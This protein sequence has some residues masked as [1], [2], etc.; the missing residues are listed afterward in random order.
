MKFKVALFSILS[1]V[2]LF[3]CSSSTDPVGVIDPAPTCPTGSAGYIGCWDT[4]GCQAIA[5]NIPDVP[6][7]WVVDRIYLTANEYRYYR[8]AY[9]DASCNGPLAFAALGEIHKFTVT[10]P[11]LGASGLMEYQLQ[12]DSNT[13]NSTQPSYTVFAAATNNALCLSNNWDVNNEGFSFHFVDGT[14][15]DLSNCLDAAP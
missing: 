12:V 8:Q 14:A 4:P 13:P 2:F 1:T 10:G 11:A 15:V 7:R 5:V 6:T 9:D 3:A